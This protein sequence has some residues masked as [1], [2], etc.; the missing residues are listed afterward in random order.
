M[1]LVG[2]LAWLALAVASLLPLSAAADVNQKNANAAWRQADR[3]GHEA[4]VKYPDYTTE[5]NAKREA[6]RRACLREHRLPEPG[7]AAAPPANPDKL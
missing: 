5:A 7:N 2:R 3:C 1:A 6:A 4:F